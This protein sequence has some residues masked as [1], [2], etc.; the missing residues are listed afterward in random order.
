MKTNPLLAFACA[1]VIFTFPL[2]AGLLGDSFYVVIQNNS[3]GQH[4]RGWISNGAPKNSEGAYVFEPIGLKC[5]FRIP[6]G[7]AMV[8][9][10]G[11]NKA[12]AQQILSA[13]L[14]NPDL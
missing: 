3:Q 2:S 14:N 9:S 13:Q 4:V 8:I 7:T 12:K 1:I 10:V 5:E 11:S 6:T